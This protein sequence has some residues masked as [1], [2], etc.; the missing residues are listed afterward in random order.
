MI[1]LV[2]VLVSIGMWLCFVIFCHVIIIDGKRS[3]KPRV[4]WYVY[5]STLMLFN[6]VFAAACC[7]YDSLRIVVWLLVIL[8]FYLGC[9][10]TETGCW[11]KWLDEG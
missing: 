11:V 10:A 5:F 6:N 3:S 7:C 4:T 8:Y 9:K 1:D 2:V